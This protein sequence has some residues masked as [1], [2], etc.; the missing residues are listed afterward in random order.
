MYRKVLFTEEIIIYIGSKN[1]ETLVRLAGKWLYE[2]GARNNFGAD[3][4]HVG[5]RQGVLHS[6]DQKY[7]S[8]SFVIWNRVLLNQTHCI[9]RRKSR[10][11]SLDASVGGFSTRGKPLNI[12]TGLIHG[13]IRADDF[14]VTCQK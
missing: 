2:I 4:L 3:A 13:V 7:C 8:A 12:E 5:R 6:T 9:P 10:K 1:E 14:G 11:Y